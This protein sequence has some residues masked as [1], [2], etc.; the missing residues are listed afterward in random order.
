[1]SWQTSDDHAAYALGHSEHELQRLATQARLIDP[2]TRRILVR[3]GITP[4][5]RVLDVGS[6][7]GDV[8]ML[9]ATLVGHGGTVI[10]TDVS[11]KAI[12]VARRRVAERGLSNISFLEGDPA[13]MSFERPFDAVAG[14]Y[15]LQFLA[16][17]SA[18][19]ARLKAHL[20]PGGVLV[21]HELDWEGARSVPPAPLYDR[22]AALCAETIRGLGAETSMGARLSAVF[23]QA[24]LAAP[25]MR[26]E[27]V[28]G[29]GQNAADRIN[30]VTDLVQTLL[31]DMERLGIVPA[32]EVDAEKLPARMLAE[33]V[34]LGSTIIGRAEI[35]AWTR[36]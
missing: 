11:A 9:I 30:L 14:R 22:F 2:I 33:A 25:T 13:E 17:P 18:T 29:S 16:D 1:M 10:G 6:G 3:A 31:P 32:G 28:I 15:V 26:L 12:E 35:G 34:S 24:G 36:V 21:F 7:V 20:A 19:L 23:E 5:M 27:A 8:A 4:G